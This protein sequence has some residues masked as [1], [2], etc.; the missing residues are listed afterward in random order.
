MAGRPVPSSGPPRVDAAGGRN[1]G[2]T[3]RVDEARA[4]ARRALS[5]AAGA[6]AARGDA[7]FA[8]A[9]TILSVA[10][11]APRDELAEQVSQWSHELSSKATKIP[12]AR[13]TARSP[14]DHAPRESESRIRFADVAPATGLTFVHRSGRDDGHGRADYRDDGGRRGGDRLRSRRVAGRVLHAGGLASAARGRGRSTHRRWMRR[15][16]SG[17]GGRSGG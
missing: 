5:T 4:W 17:G 8:W 11:V 9:A 10:A 1:A 13:E 16:E 2:R 3:G 15:A 12:P 14:A 7:S 6:G